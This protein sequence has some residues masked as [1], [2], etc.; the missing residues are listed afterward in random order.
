MTENQ[1]A[2][3]FLSKSDEAKA[4]LDATRAKKTL[5]ER[6]INDY[7]EMRYG[8]NPINWVKLSF[9]KA[10]KLPPLRKEIGKLAEQERA[11]LLTA[12]INGEA[13]LHDVFNAHAKGI[14]GELDARYQAA[15]LRRSSAAAAMSSDFAFIELTNQTIDVLQSAY[16]QADSARTMEHFDMFSSNSGISFLS[17]LETSSAADALKTAKAQ[18]ETYQQHIE[19]YR[20]DRATLTLSDHRIEGLQ[21]SNTLDLVVDMI[22]EF[23]GIFTSWDNAEKLAKAMEK[24]EP[25]LGQTRD[26]RAKV[27]DAANLS[28]LEYLN[29][30]REVTALRQQALSASTGITGDLRSNVMALLDIRN[31]ATEYFKDN[32]K[33]QGTPAI[34]VFD[35]SVLNAAHHFRKTPARRL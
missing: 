32:L 9:T 17:Y 30:D 23:A 11:T 22:S 5:T 4:Y 14:D 27:E 34:T 35:E 29:A 21:N 18:M 19:K 1:A 7:S 31:A 10:T 33:A 12:V 16:D 8:W 28:A 25:A 2:A 13:P 6:Q 26:I 15:L 24:L 3:D 20:A